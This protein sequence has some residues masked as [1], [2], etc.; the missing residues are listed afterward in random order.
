MIL[1]LFFFV[2]A[3]LLLLFFCFFCFICFFFCFIVLLFLFDKPK[4]EP[5]VAHAH[6]TIH[7]FPNMDVLR[8]LACYKSPSPLIRLLSHTTFTPWSLLRIS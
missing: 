6:P 7:C 5:T 3:L 4:A 1:F 2:F 8:I